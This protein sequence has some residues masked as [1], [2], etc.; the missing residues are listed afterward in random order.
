MS[1]NFIFV[2]ICHFKKKVV[3]IFRVKNLCVYMSYKK[4]SYVYMSFNIKRHIYTSVISWWHTHASGYKHDNSNSNE[5]ELYRPSN[6]GTKLLLKV[7]KA[8]IIIRK[9]AQVANA[10]M[11]CGGCAISLDVTPSCSSFNLWL[12]LLPGTVWLMLLLLLCK[13]ES[14][15]F[16]EALCAWIISFRFVSNSFSWHFSPSFSFFVC[17]QGLCL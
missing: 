9:Q 2:F 17:V 6:K 8:I 12:L 4:H 7:I 1:L 13:K 5:F 3:F 16:L 11:M 10:L 15:S 14:S